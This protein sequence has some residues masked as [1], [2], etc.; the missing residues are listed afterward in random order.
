MD[1]LTTQD[2]QELVNMDEGL[3]ISIYMPTYSSGVDIRQNPVKFKQLLRE[4]EARLYDMKMEKA[5]IETFLKPAANLI[6]EIR[7]WQNQG[8]GLA[9]FIHSDGI[10]YFRLPIEFKE[11][12]YINS[13][14]HI[15]PLLPL[16]TGNGQFNI[17][18]LSKNQY[19]LFRCTR[20]NI[21]EIELQDAPDSMHDVQVDDDSQDSPRRQNAMR[22]SNNVGKNQLTYNNVTQAQ[23]NEDDYE[24][25]ELTRYFRAIDESLVDMHEG[26]IVPLVLAGVE[27]LIPIYREKSKYPYIVDDFIRGNPEL[28][29]GEELHKLAWDIVEPLFNKDKKLAEEK[30][31]QYQGQRNKLYANSLERIIPAAYS[32]QIESLF[33]DNKARQWGKFNFNDNSVEIHE[34]KKDGDE[35]LMEYVSILTLSRGGNVFPVSPEEIPDNSSIAAVLRY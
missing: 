18:A 6:D 32:G 5:E 22:A 19:R 13:R 16:F 3:F 24:R 34:D 21:K 28:L 8:D 30:Y 12:V 23:G 27:Y 2:L 20:Q 29:N 35:D 17:L 15:K 7:F 33:L 25:N 14:I 4:A 1:I 26:D 10:K 11:T 31:K 9:L